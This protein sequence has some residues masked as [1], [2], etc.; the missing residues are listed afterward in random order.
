ME[1]K[2]DWA[3]NYQS[4]VL[5]QIRDEGGQHPYLS[6]ATGLIGEI[7]EMRRDEA[8]IRDMKN[9]GVIQENQWFTTELFWVELTRFDSQMFDGSN[10]PWNIS[11]K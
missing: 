8:S 6:M 9:T 11:P 4:S 10:A 2:A 5:G 3:E 7:I 1:N